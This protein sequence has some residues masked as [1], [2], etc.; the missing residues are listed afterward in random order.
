MPRL[1]LLPARQAE[2]RE[3]KTKAPKV[4]T[5]ASEE[6]RRLRRQRRRRR[7]AKKGED[8]GEDEGKRREA[9]T[10]A[11]FAK[12]KTS[13]GRCR[14]ASAS[15]AAKG[16]CS[17]NDDVQ[18]WAR[19]AVMGPMGRRGPGCNLLNDVKIRLC[20]ENIPRI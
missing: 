2:R 15:E 7:Q 8:Q 3:A 10:N 5:R 12:S 14:R 6:G 1:G 13:K 9:K 20:P 16:L 17:P 18:I 11:P 19:W 4:K